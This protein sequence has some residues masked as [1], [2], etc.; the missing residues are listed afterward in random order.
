MHN[1][2]QIPTFGCS[3]RKNMKIINLSLENSIL[4]RFLAET[5][6]TGIQKD[7][8]RFRRNIER[9]SEIMA[10]ETSK[11]LDYF[12]SNITTP[13]GTAVHRVPDDRI[14]LATLLRAGVPMHSAFLGYYDK[15]DCAFVSAYRKYSSDTEFTIESKYIATPSL[16]GK[17]LIMVDPMLAT[18]KSLITGYEALRKYG[19]P[20]K[21]ILASIIASEQAVEF[22]EKHFPHKNTSLYCATIDPSLNA[23]FYI[24]P[25]L[26]DAGDLC[27]GEKL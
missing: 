15:A 8:L 22:I 23:H 24:V 18:G 3:V 25:G 7:R 12:P 20:S 10:Y 9:I 16:E 27:F 6:D 14:V 5:R 1:N 13:L 21:V 2:Q 17:T 4:G 11:E 26:G 19:E